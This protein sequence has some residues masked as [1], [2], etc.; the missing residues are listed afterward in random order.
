MVFRIAENQYKRYK[1]N[2]VTLYAPAR[3]NKIYKCDVVFRMEESKTNP[4]SQTQFPYLPQ[5][6]RKK[7][8]ENRDLCKVH[9]F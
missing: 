6:P 5:Y 1:P 8:E 2:A 3:S 7:A 9:K 4:I